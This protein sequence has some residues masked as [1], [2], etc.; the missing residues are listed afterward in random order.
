MKVYVGSL[1]PIVVVP[2]MQKG[3]WEIGGKKRERRKKEGGAF[4]SIHLSMGGARSKKG[5]QEAITCS[6]G[7]AVVVEN[8]VITAEQGLGV[9]V[10][11]RVTL[12][13]RTSRICRHLPEVLPSPFSEDITRGHCDSTRCCFCFD[14]QKGGRQWWYWG[15]KLKGSVLERKG[16][17][18][19][20]YR[21][22]RIQNLI[23]QPEIRHFEN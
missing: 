10:R 13:G 12:P 22:C 21:E 2:E 18:K 6:I 1:L 20:H 14:E 11:R 3:K 5:V 9:R 23:S 8:G 15:K 16:R 19:I 4:L 7:Q 17:C